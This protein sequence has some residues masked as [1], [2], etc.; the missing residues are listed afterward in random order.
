MVEAISSIGM[1]Q[2]TLDSYNIDDG[3]F[4]IALDAATDLLQETNQAELVTTQLTYDFMTGQNEDI[5][6][7]MIAQEKSSILLNFTMQ[8]RNKIMSAYDE[9]MQIPV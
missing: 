7:L 5:H 6:S 2:K 9:I 8:V 4:K 3:A 1:Y